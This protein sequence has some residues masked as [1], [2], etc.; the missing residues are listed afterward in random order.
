M[1]EITAKALRD[2]AGLLG[3]SDRASLNEIRN[4]YHECIRE[5]HPDVSRN[6]PATSHDMTIRLKRA[7]DTL[8]DYCMNHPFSFRIDDLSRNL[9][10]APAD[11][12]MERFGDDPIWG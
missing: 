6:D 8:V 5:W 4:R 12:W 10:D 9:E 1:A 2:A 7:Y 11:L 3:I